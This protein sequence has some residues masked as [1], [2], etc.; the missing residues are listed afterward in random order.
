[1]TYVP[2]VTP[3]PASTPPSPRTRELAGLLTR[4]V[5]EYSA[6]HPGVTQAEI[7]QAIQITQLSARGGSRNASLVVMLVVGL[8]VGGLTLGLFVAEGGGLPWEGAF[9]VLIF[10]II[11]LVALAMIVFKMVSR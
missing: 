1:M 6:A 5:E 2:I 8:L 11:L 3:S 9:P 4:V 10:A 7:R